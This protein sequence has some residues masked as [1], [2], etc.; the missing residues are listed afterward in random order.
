MRSERICYERKICETF[1]SCLFKVVMNDHDTCKNQLQ[2]L[3]A[4][5]QS[6]QLRS[7]TLRPCIDRFAANAVKNFMCNQVVDIWNILPEEVIITTS[8][9]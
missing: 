9:N 3:H 8:V 6:I 4:Y 1:K 5:T 2:H 7:H